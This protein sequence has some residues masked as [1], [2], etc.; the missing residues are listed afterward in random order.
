MSSRLAF[1]YVRLRGALLRVWG[2]SP[3]GPPACVRSGRGGCQCSARHYC[4]N[5][6]CLAL[7]L[8]MYQHLL[9]E[10]WLPLGPAR[11]PLPL[12]CCLW[13]TAGARCGWAQSVVP[14]C[15]C[16]TVRVLL[17]DAFPL[18]HDMAQ[19]LRHF[20]CPSSGFEGRKC[21][22]LGWGRTWGLAGLRSPTS[23]L[24]GYQP[25]CLPVSGN[26]RG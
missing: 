24:T 11:R 16:C 17:G 4:A 13:P 21:T 20:A 7:A 25:Y 3:H 8:G 14:L 15:P 26:T 19:S 1:C 9:V 6:L 22:F 5:V 23:L 18:A 2:G 10:S 12:Q